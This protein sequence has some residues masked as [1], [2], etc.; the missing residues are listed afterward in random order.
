MHH[1]ARERGDLVPLYERIYSEDRPSGMAL[2]SFA[3]D[4]QAR[5]MRHSAESGLPFLMPQA[6][7]RG[8]LHVYDEVN[9]LLHHMTELYAARGVSTRPLEAAISRFMSWLHDRKSAYNRHRSWRYED[10]DAEL[11]SLCEE[12][13]GSAALSEVI[14]NDKLAAFIGQVVRDRKVLD[15]VTLELEDQ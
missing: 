7:Y 14:G 11:A 6:L 1:L 13:G 8:H 9:V 3:S 12:S 15:Y 2:R 10:L 4:L 5:L